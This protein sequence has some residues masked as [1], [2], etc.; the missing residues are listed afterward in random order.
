MD[1]LMIKQLSHKNPVLTIYLLMTSLLIVYLFSIYVFKIFGSDPL[2]CQYRGF[3]SGARQAC[4][5]IEYFWDN[6]FWAAFV[7]ILLQIFL[8]P[9]TLITYFLSRF[10]QNRIKNKYNERLW[11]K[12]GLALL[13]YFVIFIIFFLKDKI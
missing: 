9:A 10:I 13:I 5:A 1:K 6:V 12:Y 11:Y 2:T 7:V 4:N 8:L 3:G